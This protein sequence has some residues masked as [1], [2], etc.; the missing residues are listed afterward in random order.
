[1]SDN[2][3]PFWDEITNPELFRRVKSNADYIK[4]S[5]KE[6]FEDRGIDIK[7]LTKIMEALPEGAIV[8][9]GYL[10]GLFAGEE[11]K[12]IDIFFTCSDA[13]VETIEAIT[14]HRTDPEHVF[15]GYETKTNI[16]GMFEEP[17]Y[18][19]S[20]RVLDYINKYTQSKPK[21]QLVKSIWYDDPQHII[22]TFDFTV[23]QFATDGKFLYANPTSFIDL[24]RKRLVL[25]RMTFPAS[26]LRRLIK[27]ANKG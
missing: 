25:H 27:Y 14:G 15:F 3:V 18:S 8:A 22:D 17:N 7:D 4:L 5:L 20:I 12:D 21:I 13:L 1:M 24:S 19:K 2:L 23:A 10:C 11:S 26:T 16:D 6:V 9:G